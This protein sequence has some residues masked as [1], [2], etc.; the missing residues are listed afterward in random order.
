MQVIWQSS[1]SGG[2]KAL[3]DVTGVPVWQSSAAGGRLAYEGPAAVGPSPEELLP[4]AVANDSGWTP[5][6]TFGMW[7]DSSDATSSTA[8]SGDSVDAVFANTAQAGPFTG[9]TYR[10]RASTNIAAQADISSN[11]LSDTLAPSD[12]TPRNYDFPLPGSYTQADINN[13]TDLTIS[14]AG[15]FGTLTIYRV[16]IEIS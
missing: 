2:Q 11:F 13:L 10:I 9:L 1:P 3:I 16:A 4:T 8:D 14:Y 5:A 6:V 12:G 15:G 7:A